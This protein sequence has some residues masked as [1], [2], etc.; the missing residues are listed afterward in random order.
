[1]N[2]E[3]LEAGL[4]AL[5][6]GGGLDSRKPL[7]AD[8]FKALRGKITDLKVG[9][10]LRYLGTGHVRIPSKGDTV[11]VASLE[12]PIIQQESGASIRRYDFTAVFKDSD[13]DLFEFAFDSR[14]FER[15]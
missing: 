3:M 4:M 1:M 2:K 15:V 6:L 11:I 5:L 8:E 9:D 12:V 10:E 13:G 7:K 14:H